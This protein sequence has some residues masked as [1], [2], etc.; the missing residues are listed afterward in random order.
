M[1]GS[2]ALAER[3]G[4]RWPGLLAEHNRILREAFSAHGGIE[5]GTEGDAFFVGFTEAGP[6]A[7]AAA[8]AQRALAAHAWADG[9]AVRVRMGL[10][11]GQ[12][13]PTPDGYVGLD[14]HRAARVA[15]AAHGGQVL[16]SQSTRDLLAEGDGLTFRDLG[17]HRV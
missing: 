3:V 1:E 16:V 13:T 5:L 10:H 2:T 11:T 14:M 9:E 17:D 6:A 8:E 15:A 7:A 4:D 12:P